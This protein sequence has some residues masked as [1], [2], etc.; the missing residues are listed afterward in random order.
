MS[1]HR[2]AAHAA[3]A[4]GTILTLAAASPAGKPQLGTYGFDTTGMDRSIKPGD[5]WFGYANGTW[6]RTTAIPADRP[7]YGMFYVLDDLSKTRTRAILEGDAASQPAGTPGRKAAD[8]YHAFMDEAAIEARGIQ[9][10]KAEMASIAAISNQTGLAR[11]MGAL[12]RTGVETP[13]GFGVGVDKKNPDAYIPSMRQSGLGL[14]DRDYYLKT[15]A[16]MVATRAKYVTHIANML[17]LAGYA[18]PEGNSAKIFALETEIARAHWTRV[19]SRQADKTYNKL[20]FAALPTTA[21]GFDWNAFAAGANLSGQN[22]LIVAQPSAISGEAKLI[23]ATP[24]DTM[25][26][27]LAYNL[28]KAR[29]DVLP[30]AIVDENFAFNGRTLNGTPELRARWKRGVDESTGA[31]GEAIGPI[32]VAKYFTPASKAAADDLVKNILAAM[33]A[34]LQTIAWMDPQTRA[35]AVEKLAAFRPKIGYP[36]K[37]RDYSRLEVRPDDAY[38]ND[39]RATAFEWDRNVR[40]IADKTDRGEWFMTAMTINAYAN[41]TWN[42]IV[43]PAAILQPP[44]FDAAADPAINYGAIGAVIGHEISHHFDDQ[45]RKFDATGRLADWWT[46]GDVERFGKLTDRLAAQYDAYEPLPGTH[47]QG[48]LTLGENIADV[49]GITVALDAYHRSLKG[50]PAPVIDGLTG[51]QRFYLGFAQVW[52]GK[53]RPENLRVR[54][55]SDPHSPEA[56]RARTVRNVDAWYKAWGAK[57]GE[58]LYLAPADRVNIW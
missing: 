17:R 23:A 7:A 48:K 14:P 50:K 36:D 30:K 47:I 44:F 37:W 45:G 10:L 11:T 28:V 1:S 41:P 39:A 19:E 18:D 32:Y 38:G 26:A 16:A 13:F 29:A 33:N 42:E 52:R 5:D 25:K 43:F 58:A 15:D 22:D 46:P 12:T 4:L 49:V 56:Y 35:K 55:A 9:P 3:L 24:L 31:L 54:L 51:D 34:R 6:A 21:P 53:M 2:L 27:Y 8:Y 57:P 40:R 20:T